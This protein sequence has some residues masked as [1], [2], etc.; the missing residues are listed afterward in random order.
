[1]INYNTQID[2]NKYALLKVILETVLTE[3]LYNNNISILKIWTIIPEEAICYYNNPKLS[4]EYK[5]SFTVNSLSVVS[6]ND[7]N[8]LHFHYTDD[9][10]LNLLLTM[11]LVDVPELNIQMYETIKNKVILSLL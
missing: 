2:L 8:S 9:R 1:M 3:T 11:G 6:S 10:V 5:F 7:T 4:Q